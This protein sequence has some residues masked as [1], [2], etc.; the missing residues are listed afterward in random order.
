[1]QLVPVELPFTNA[2]GY[3]KTY[4]QIVF[5]VAA[6]LNT[7]PLISLP[8]MSVPMTMLLLHFTF[9]PI[10][11]LISDSSTAYFDKNQYFTEALFRNI[12]GTSFLFLCFGLNWTLGLA[13]FAGITF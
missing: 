9:T 2:Y 8:L 10:I 3:D 4:S 11:M 12:G 5:Y 1:M 6:A 13:P 7:I